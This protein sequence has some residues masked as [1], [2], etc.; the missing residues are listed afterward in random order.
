MIELVDVGV[1]APDGQTAIL[2]DV[3]GV[4]SEQRIAL[5]GANGSG[6]STLARLV[7]G[8]VRPTTGR[9]IVDG[10]D[11][12]EHTVAVRKKVGFCFTDPSAQFAMPTAIEDVALSLRRA[13][14]RRAERHDAALAI[15]DR[16]GLAHRAEVSVHALSGGQK[17]LLAL[18]GVLAIEPAIVVADE[19]TTLLD[20]SNTRRVAEVLFGLDQQLIVATHDLALAAR[21]ERGIVVSDGR[22]A[23]DGPADDAVAHYMSTVGP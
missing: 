21:C 20:L 3:N 1:T 17:Q 18:A 8:L 10:L 13:Y 15:L 14:P 2:T 5:I 7:N 22:I 12:A 9:V 6:K 4:W 23:F 19:P 16:Y 11:V